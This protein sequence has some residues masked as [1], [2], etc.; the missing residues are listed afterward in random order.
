MEEDEDHLDVLPVA[1]VAAEA[2]AAEDR[3]APLPHPVD[4]HVADE[5]QEDEDHLRTLIQQ[6]WQRIGSAGRRC[7]SVAANHD[8]VAD[9]AGG[10][11][12]D[13]LDAHVA[14]EAGEAEAHAAQVAAE[15]EEADARVA[16]THPDRRASAT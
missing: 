1:R 16:D 9:E 12:E 6:V 15:A 2:G 11:A 14:A 8:L 4:A 3:D 7:W 13:H 10:A 5:V